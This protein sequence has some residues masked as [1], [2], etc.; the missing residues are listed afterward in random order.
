MGG[1]TPAPHQREDGGISK[2]RERSGRAL[3]SAA[4]REGSIPPKSLFSVCRVAG[5]PSGPTS[6]G[7]RMRL[8]AA[9]STCISPIS[10]LNCLHLYPPLFKPTPTPYRLLKAEFKV[11]SVT[12]ATADGHRF[13]IFFR[14]GLNGRSTHMR[15]HTRVHPPVQSLG[16][17]E[18]QWA[19]RQMLPFKKKNPPALHRPGR[20]RPHLCWKKK[21]NK[22]TGSK[23]R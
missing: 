19:V 2:C 12:T 7:V 17:T 20:P 9:V 4:V 15:T 6:P 10:L 14:S 11:I 5:S 16:Q 23:C 3:S 21:K 1:E 13:F 18:N 8:R 22:Q